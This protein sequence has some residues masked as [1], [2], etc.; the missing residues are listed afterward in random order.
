VCVCVY[1]YIYIYIYT[2]THTH[3]HTHTQNLL[4]GRV[5]AGNELLQISNMCF[6]QGIKTPRR[7]I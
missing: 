7:D 3:T 5:V 1:I 6:F 4:H 2:H